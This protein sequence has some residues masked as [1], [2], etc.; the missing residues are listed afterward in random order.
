MTDEKFQEAEK[1]NKNREQVEDELSFLKKS[2]YC[3]IKLYSDTGSHTKV[4]ELNC[5]P[6]SVIYTFA[7]KY[8]T[9]ELANLEE[10]FKNL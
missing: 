5:I 3:C 9:K 1:I 7:S 6:M 4:K 2:E 10:Q 8:L